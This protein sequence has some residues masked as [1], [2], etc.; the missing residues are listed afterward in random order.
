MGR[1]ISVVF[2]IDRK[3]YYFLRFRMYYT[4]Y[5][6]DDNVYQN[7]GVVKMRKVINAGDIQFKTIY[8]DSGFTDFVGGELIDVFAGIKCEIDDEVVLM[9]YLDYDE[10]H[11]EFE[12]HVQINGQTAKYDGDWLSHIDVYISSRLIGNPVKEQL[13]IETLKWCLD[14]L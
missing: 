2:Y 13:S 7:L 8:S 3:V 4:V 9:A 6:E 12:T 10:D 14:V 11:K 1:F 5:Y